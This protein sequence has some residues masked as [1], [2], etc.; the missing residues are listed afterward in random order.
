MEIQVK[1]IEETK[2]LYNK[3]GDS[4]YKVELLEGDNIGKIRY[5]QLGVFLP[6]G[7]IA[8]VDTE[9]VCR[10]ATEALKS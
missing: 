10:T 9:R 7:Y 5:I 1:I 3:A 4:V 8:T 2:R 6:V